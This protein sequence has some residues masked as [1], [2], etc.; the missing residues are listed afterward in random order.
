MNIKKICIK[1]LLTLPAIGLGILA[2]LIQL[3]FS[4][5][6]WLRTFVLFQPI[7]DLW[8]PNNLKE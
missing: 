6:E 2:L 3:F 4:I 7:I 5:T 1:I 8:F